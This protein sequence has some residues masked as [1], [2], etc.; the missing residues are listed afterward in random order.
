MGRG[1]VTLGDNVTLG[2]VVDALAGKL[3]AVRQLIADAVDLA[4][5]LEAARTLAVGAEAALGADYY[6]ANDN[7]ADL[8]VS[9][10]GPDEMGRGRARATTDRLV[11]AY[12]H[13]A[14]AFDVVYSPNSAFI[15]EQ[16]KAQHLKEHQNEQQEQE[17]AYAR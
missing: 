7:I 16:L 3:G 12:K 11:R 13:V 10:A 5:A 17:A 6:C 14:D 1:K 15:S 9:Q 8:L 4:E 2:D